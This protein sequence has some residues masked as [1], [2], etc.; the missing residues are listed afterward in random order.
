MFYVDNQ[1]NNKKNNDPVWLRI[2]PAFMVFVFFFGLTIWS[3]LNASTQIN[4]GQ[5]RSVAQQIERTKA[6]VSYR[7]SAYEGILRAGAGY[8][9][10]SDN[11]VRREWQQF[12]NSIDI[13]TRYPG[14]VGV[15]FARV[16]DPSQIKS[17]T[18]QMIAE[19]HSKY[20]FRP[21]PSGDQLIYT[22]IDYLEP[23][24][25]T[26]KSAIGYDM[27]SEPVRRKAMLLAMDTGQATIS[28]PV[29]LVQDGSEENKQP[30]F[31]MYMP[32]YETGAASDTVEQ[33]RKSI[34][35]FVYAPFR[36]YDFLD[37]TVEDNSSVYG[38]Q[39]RYGN[40]DNGQIIYQ[41]PSYNAI[42]QQIGT[43]SLSGYMTIYNVEWSI[44]GLGSP[45]GVPLSERNRVMN[46]F[47]GGIA[48]SALT[49]GF[50]FLLLLNRSRALN[51]NKNKELQAAKDELLA[52][53]SHQLRTPATGVKQYIS[54]LR[55]GYVGKLTPEQL[56]FA[57]KAFE[58][59]ERQLRTIN[60]MLCVARMDAGRIEVSKIPFNLTGLL[61]TMH[62]EH[63]HLAMQHRLRFTLE[64]PNKPILIVADERYIRMAVENLISNAIKYTPE[65]GKVILRLKTTPI[66]AIIQVEDS[67]VGVHAKD[68]HLLFKKFSRIPNELT[69]RV[70][71]TGIGLYIVQQIA[72]AHQGR[73]EYMPAK[74]TG[75]I[76]EIIVPLDPDISE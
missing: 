13:D 64:L 71:G 8:Y 49:S 25:E 55:E 23:A 3:S 5:Y 11:I 33:R 50:I 44:N 40:S 41:S 52:L 56:N 18:S 60:E 46:T 66:S 35:G 29:V 36:M 1:S 26:N 19:G 53:T 31:L 54:M 65:H 32:V 75:S 45:L 51:H 2:V 74:N 48:L 17:H 24:T 72:A 47:W 76:F 16:L 58:S 28:E 21:A 10:G 27:F 62:E 14:I 38:Y 43:Y 20:N 59:N 15:G 7:L 12:I 4:D 22:A 61:Q 6:S 69:S 57:N 68:Q 67:G 70:S 30:G 9:G 39:I 73:V 37:S 34:I 63:A 42:N